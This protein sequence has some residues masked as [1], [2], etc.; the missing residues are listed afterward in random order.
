[1]LTDEI[2]QQL[3]HIIWGAVIEGQGDSCRKVR[4]HLCTSFST[5]RTVKKDFEGQSVIKEKQSLELKKWALEH[6]CWLTDLSP[7][8]QYL[9]HGGEARIYLDALNKNVIKLNQGI[10]YATWLEYFN[11]LVLHNLCSH[12]PLMTLLVLWKGTTIWLPWFNS[13]L[14][15]QKALP[16]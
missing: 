8:W 3:Q 10:Y 12:T 9:T 7:S 14:F 15:L 11:S 16:A 2:R 5:S 6:R 13:L 4:N 1:M